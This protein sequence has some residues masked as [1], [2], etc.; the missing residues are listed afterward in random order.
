MDSKKKKQASTLFSAPIRPPTLFH[1]HVERHNLLD[2]LDATKRVKR[3]LTGDVAQLVGPVGEDLVHD[4]YSQAFAQVISLYPLNQSGAREGD[5]V[6]DSY[7]VH[8]TDT[9]SV[10]CLADGCNWGPRP[11][12]AANRYALFFFSPKTSSPSL[13]AAL[14]LLYSKTHYH[15]FLFSICITN[16]T[17]FP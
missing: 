12:Q 11:F 14:F 5:P 7:R 6:C 16:P 4:E 8:T 13:L 17:T 2:E 3:I 1:T 10:W 9:G 15:M